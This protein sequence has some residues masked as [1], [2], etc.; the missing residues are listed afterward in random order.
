MSL[1]VFPL[2]WIVFW[3]ALPVTVALV[4]YGLDIYALIRR[5][6]KG[7]RNALPK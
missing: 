7:G 5:K 1:E 4:L 3:V 6:R 2:P